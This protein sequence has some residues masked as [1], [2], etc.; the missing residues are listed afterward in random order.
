MLARQRLFRIALLF[1]V[2][3]VG[4]LPGTRSPI[5]AAAPD[6]VSGGAFGPQLFL[7]SPTPEKVGQLAGLPG[8]IHAALYT[9]GPERYLAS[10]PATLPVAA[11]AIG[12]SAEMLDADTAGKVYYFVD[13]QALE[14]Q[15]QAARFGTI[16]Y[17]DAWQLVLAVPLENEAGLLVTLPL[18]GISL[19]L[20]PATALPLDEPP[21]MVAAAAPLSP[22][23]DSA[24]E[25][26][27]NQVTPATLSRFIGELSGDSPAMVDGTYVTLATRYTFAAGIR[28]AE[29]YLAQRY[30]ELG[31]PVTYANWT[32]G[33]YSGRNVVAELR[34]TVYPE[35]IWLVGGHFD[36]ISETPYSHAPGADDN[37]TG[38]ASALTLAGI[39]KQHRFRDTIRFIHFS[40]EEQGHWG[41]IVYARSLNTAGAQGQGY[42]NLDMIGWDG[43]NDRTLEIHS[44]TRANSIDLAGRFTSANQRYNQGLRVELKQSSASRFSDHASF[45]DYGY[46]SFLAIE[47]FFDDAIPRDRNPWYHTTGDRLSRVN[48]DYVART[49]R[50]TLALLAEA[51]GLQSG[52]APTATWTATA[53]PTRMWTSTPSACPELV[54]NG[55]FE[56]A[57][58]WTFAATATQARYS[59]AY[60]H[61]GARS[62]RL[63]VVPPAAAAGLGEEMI[64]TVGA[65][66]TNLLGESAPLGASYSTAYQTITVPA[67]APA[68]TLTFWVRP[69]AEAVAGNGDYQRVLLLKPGSYSYLAT[70]TKMLANATAWQ[71]VSFDLTPYRGQQVVLYFEVLNDNTSAAPR[72]WLYVD[73]VSARPCAPALTPTATFTP[74]PATATPSPT[75]ALAPPTVTPTPTATIVAPSPTATRT[76]DLP[77][78][79]PTSTASPTATPISS[80]QCTERVINGDFENTTG[81]IFARTANPGGYTTTIT[82]SGARAGR[83]G[84]VM[85]GGL[86][87]LE[88]GELA[89]DATTISNLLG[90]AA[91]ADASYS[92]AY[93]TITLPADADTLTL[94]FWYWPGTQAT[95]GN[96]D[97]QRVLLLRPGTYAVVKTLTKMLANSSGWHEAWFDLAPYRG[98][99]LVLYFEVYNDNINAGPRTWLYVDDVAVT[100]CVRLTGAGEPEVTRPVYLP[101]VIVAAP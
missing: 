87:A 46:A 85:G 96:G 48:L 37:A 30:M 4:I 35:R 81:W 72:T 8:D 99:S 39:L 74:A 28:N 33:S 84:V 20:I 10:G 88:A 15:A 66:A 11:A 78:V 97:F 67:G 51:A 63:G 79:T 57:T 41:S 34:G 101:L 53:T 69:G 44:G 6:T 86:A 32:Y 3:L 7:L 13:V 68:A 19:A 25:A 54:T 42:V 21:G 27:L 64:V 22:A 92:T 58:G 18:A 76:P 98:Q 9:D 36:S 50:T 24:I 71:Q 45:W 61:T 16:L 2:A 49:A 80:Q 59:T 14:A 43:D 60:A 93:Q 38:T 95:A 83:L 77:T 47:N 52:S 1:I 31:L 62:V 75:A 17:W 5:A 70:V 65:T 73:D 23:K 26:M 94:R 40:G 91:P 90:E 55:G 12:I 82:H 29:K 56:S 89:P 100:T